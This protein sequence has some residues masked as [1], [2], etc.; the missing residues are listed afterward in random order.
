MKTS[1]S[2]AGFL[3]PLRRISTTS[4]MRTGRNGEVESWAPNPRLKLKQ[5]RSFSPKKLLKECLR[6]HSC[7]FIICGFFFNGKKT[8]ET[9]LSFSDRKS[10]RLHSSHDE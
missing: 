6:D 4:M 9:W 8:M 3:K 2:S 1:W 5:R 7:P 10:T